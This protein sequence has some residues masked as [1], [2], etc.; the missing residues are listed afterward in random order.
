MD[1]YEGRP[2]WGKRH[3]QKA[4]TLAPRY[5]EWDRFQAAR[6]RLDPSGVFQNEYARALGRSGPV[7]LR[8]V[9]ALTLSRPCT[10]AGGRIRPVFVL[11]A[12]PRTRHDARHERTAARRDRDL[13]GRPADRRDRAGRGVPHGGRARSAG[14]LG[15]ARGGE[16][17]HGAL[18]DRRPRA[19]TA[20]SPAAAA[21]STRCSSPAAPGVAG[22]PGRAPRLLA[23]RGREALAAGVL[24]LHRH[25]PAGR[26]RAAGGPSRHDALGRAATL[27]A[28]QYPVRD[29]RAGPHLR[30]R[31]RRCT[32]PPA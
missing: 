9:T 16:P 26:S 30:A 18:L 3:F 17:G 2:H 28:E 15:R 29:R 6:A 31:R 13:P 8:A 1:D 4:A 22:V 20:R 10:S 24:G 11:A 12:K 25:V 19:S 21:R 32:P 14:L 27:L 5:P 7:E 23:A